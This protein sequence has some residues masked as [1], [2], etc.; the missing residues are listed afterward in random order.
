MLNQ[1]WVGAKYL[2]RGVVG[3]GQKGS[4]IGEDGVEN[5]HNPSL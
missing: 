4:K 5:N 1:I 3:G 2:G